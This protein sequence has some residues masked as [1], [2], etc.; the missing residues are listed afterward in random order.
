MRL[1]P[2]AWASL[3]STHTPSYN[4]L[5]PSSATNPDLRRHRAIC[6]A[7]P[8]RCHDGNMSGAESVHCTHPAGL[9]PT[10]DRVDVSGLETSEL[11]GLVDFSR[12]VILTNVLPGRECELWCEALLEDLG[13]V[14]VDFQ[15]RDNQDGGSEVFRSSLGDFV[16][17][18]Q[19]ESSHGESW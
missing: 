16:D 5:R 12:P 1:S 19:E 11:R 7:R 6:M 3:L 9:E 2:N 18:L 15:I 4:L 17:G 14:T 10:L 13:G 8:L